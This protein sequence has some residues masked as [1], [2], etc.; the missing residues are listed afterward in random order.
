MFTTGGQLLLIAIVFSTARRRNGYAAL[1]DLATG[2]RVVE[3]RMADAVEHRVGMA[4]AAGT[5]RPAIGAR[6]PFTVLDG[7]IDGR[8]GWR[9]GVDDRLRRN[10]WLRD[11]PVGTPAVSV[12]R[13]SL[14]RPTRLRWLAG[15]R[16][17]EEAWDVYEGVAGMPILDACRTRRPWAEV[18]RWLA[19]LAHELAAQRPDDRAPLELD[20]VW[21]LDSGRAK[22]LDDPTADPEPA[23]RGLAK[24]LALL[25]AMARAAR[26]GSGQPWPAAAERFVDGLTAG[27]PASLADVAHAADGLLRGRAA[28][29]R[30]W[31]G[32]S[33]A[34]LVVLPALM[35]AI[36][37]GGMTAMRAAL[38]TAPP[39]E[40]TAAYVLRALDG[41][42]SDTLTP[43]DREA[44]EIVLAA[45]YRSTLADERFYRPERFLL[46]TPASRA[47]A[48][49]ILRRHD[50][51]VTVEAAAARPAIRKLL[52]DSMSDQLPPLAPIALFMFFGMLCVIAVSGLIAAVAARGLLLRLLGFELVT[53]DGRRASRGRVLLRAAIAWSPLLV[54]VVVSTALGGMAGGLWSLTAMLGVALV[55]QLAGAVIAIARPARGLQDRLAGTWIVPR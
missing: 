20:R 51:A 31:R 7:V 25:A 17:A 23:A 48:G 10:V 36:M 8:P 2:C 52:G 54:P 26:T 4:T 16:T 28:I 33:I 21:I 22:L 35:V 30:G 55:I 43:A 18:R 3:R 50:G 39:D 15:R 14:A 6:G 9:P 27:Q 42:R 45:R 46:L 41:P 44:A 49:A 11:L 38:A 40:R 24:P 1:H 19:D 53:S 5:G 13:A 47:R 32:L 12:P 29:T 37:F 34:G